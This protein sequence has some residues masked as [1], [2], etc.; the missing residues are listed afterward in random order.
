MDDLISAILLVWIL[1][2]VLRI[3]LWKKRGAGDG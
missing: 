3:D 2:E 1:R